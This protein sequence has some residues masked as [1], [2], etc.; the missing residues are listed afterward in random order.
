MMEIFSSFSNLHL[1]RAKSTF[2]GFGLSMAEMTLCAG[3]LETPIRVLPIQYLGMPLSE[4][5]LRVAGWQPVLD[6]VDARLR[7][8]QGRL[9]SRGGRLVLVKAVL[10]AIPSYFML[11]FQMPGG[12]RRR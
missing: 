3:I 2:V 7:G 9:L 10:S 6:T 11:V 5:R 1:N 8:W 4:R 12:V